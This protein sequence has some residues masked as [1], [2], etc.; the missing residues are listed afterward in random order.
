[1]STQPPANGENMSGEYAREPQW[2]HVD[3]KVLWIGETYVDA[4]IFRRHDDGGVTVIARDESGRRVGYPIDAR[5]LSD[6]LEARTQ[7]ENR[8]EAE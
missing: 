7:R 2:L 1:M 4:V 5:S 8:R 3:P 6:W